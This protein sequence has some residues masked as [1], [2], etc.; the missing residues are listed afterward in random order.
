MAS[1]YRRADSPFIW[2]KYKDAA[3]R[4]KSANTGYRQDNISDR[5]QAEKLARKKSAEEAANKT[6]R[7]HEYKFEDWVP[8]WMESRW[9]S[10][11]KTLSIYR[12][13]FLKLSR[14]FADIQITHPSTLRF[15]TEDHQLPGQHSEG[16]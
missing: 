13:Y 9:G 7:V 8:A 12:R 5:T 4:W 2:I 10:R 16:W 11:V 15:W 14:Y 3:G 6:V 1:T